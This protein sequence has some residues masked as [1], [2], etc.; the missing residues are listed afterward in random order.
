MVSVINVQAQVTPLKGFSLTSSS[1]AS[2]P[3]YVIVSAN[4]VNP[5][6]AKVQYVNCR[7]DSN[8]TALTFYTSSNG[9]ALTTNTTT[10]LIFPITNSYQTL[11]PDSLFTTNAGLVVIRHL[12]SDTYELRTLTSDGASPTNL[13]VLVAP[14]TACSAG[15][16][17]YQMTASASIPVGTNVTV[18]QWAN[19]GAFVV[20]PTP[21]G[22]AWGS[23]QC[24]MLVTLNAS[25][26]ASIY[27]LSGTYA[28]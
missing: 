27:D 25:N 3:A 11:I 18:G 14:T 6:P 8:Y 4:S 22:I 19:G 10:K 12:A 16:M 2:S 21:A 28:P 5:G 23:Y 24:P 20:G 9:I 17:V 26:A 1:N 15:D 13:L 7:S